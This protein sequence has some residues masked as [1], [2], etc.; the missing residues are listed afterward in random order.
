[1]QSL[2]IRFPHRHSEARII[3][4]LDQWFYQYDILHLVNLVTR[5]HETDETQSISRAAA[6]RAFLPVYEPDGSSFCTYCNLSRGSE[7]PSGKT[8]W[9]CFNTHLT[10]FNTTHL[11]KEP[12]NFRAKGAFMIAVSYKIM[13]Y[14]YPPTYSKLLRFRTQVF[15]QV[16]GAFVRLRDEKRTFFSPDFSARFITLGPLFFSIARVSGHPGPTLKG[17]IRCRML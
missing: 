2:T 16:G 4:L 11:P 9:T 8:V 1:M 7:R 10:H 14:L 3:T 6:S 5:T 17:W 12:V 15:F 13:L